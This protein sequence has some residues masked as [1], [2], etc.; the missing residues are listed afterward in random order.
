[1]ACAYVAMN[2][3]KQFELWA[4]AD[5]PYCYLRACLEV[6]NLW[7]RVV[8]QRKISHPEEF[9][10]TEIEQERFF[11]ALK[12][13]G[14]LHNR[15]ITFSSHLPIELDQSNSAFAHIGLLMNDVDLQERANMGTVWN[16]LYTEIAEK[17]LLKRDGLES[18][19][20]QR[21]II[22]K[23]SVPWSYGAGAR[24]CADALLK[25]RNEDPDKSPYLWTLEIEQINDLVEDVIQILEE[26]FNTCVR[27]TKRVKKAVTAA[28]NSGKD[29]VEYFSPFGFQVVHRKY[30]KKKRDDDVW[31]GEKWIRPRAYRPTKPNWSKQRTSTPAILVHSLDAALIHGVLALGNMTV[32][33]DSDQSGNWPTLQLQSQEFVDKEGETFPIITIHDCFACHASVAPNLQKILLRGLAAMYKHFDPLNA[34]LGMVEGDGNYFKDRDIS[35]EQWA[36]NAFS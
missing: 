32:K 9:L 7:S 3:E 15:N 27:Y 35:W 10:E 33:T 4:E 20:E 23:V 30:G 11:A 1:M 28:K 16:D 25:L 2:P 5:K 14:H 34:F 12:E 24:K 36:K 17:N 8:G 29:C 22:K 6:A 19:G 21:K 18:E 13:R 26:E 31:S